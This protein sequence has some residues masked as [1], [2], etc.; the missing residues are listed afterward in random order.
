MLMRRLAA[1]S[2]LLLQT[3]GCARLFHEPAQYARIPPGATAD[4]EPGGRTPRPAARGPRVAAVDPFAALRQSEADRK[5]WSVERPT[6]V[7]KLQWPSG[8]RGLARNDAPRDASGPNTTASLPEGRAGEAAAPPAAARNPA[9]K[10]AAAKDP[11]GRDAGRPPY[12][13]ESVMN[14][15]L[16]SGDK[17]AR[18]ICQGC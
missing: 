6:D 2:L 15:L 10:V 18:P 9:N 13:G 11:A 17:V 14:R 7:T 16:D 3:S 8:M 5:R 1:A 4:D 12:D